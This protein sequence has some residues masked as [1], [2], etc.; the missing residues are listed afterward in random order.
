MSKL[1]TNLV[2][3]FAPVEGDGTRGLQFEVDNAEAPTGKKYVRLYGATKNTVV[4]AT[5]GSQVSKGYQVAEKKVALSFTGGIAANLPFMNVSSVVLNGS[6]TFFNKKGEATAVKL[7]F[8]PD[9]NALVSDRPVY[10]VIMATVKAQYRKL[11]VTFKGGP[12]PVDQSDLGDKGTGD[13]GLDGVFYPMML[14]G[15]DPSY[16]KVAYLSLD[17]PQCNDYNKNFGGFLRSNDRKLA[18]MVLEIEGSGGKVTG[19]N[20]DGLTARTTVRVY[21]AVAPYNINVEATTGVIK[22]AGTSTK[23]LGVKEVVQYNGSSIMS[24]KYPTKA[25]IAVVAQSSFADASGRPLLSARVRLPGQAINMVEWQSDGSYKPLGTR[26]LGEGEIAIVNGFG[27][28][29]RVWG[30]LQ[31]AYST[32][33]LEYTYTPSYSGD[34]RKFN[35]GMIVAQA[36]DR[37]ATLSIS[38]PSLDGEWGNT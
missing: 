13:A 12:C 23:V 33:Y 29:V 26:T 3:S 9:L 8:D 20:S 2:A 6:G 35:Q 11:E 34:T 14:I 22:P 24:T 30:G 27:H 38:G 25:N 18:P 4:R 31:I 10:G 16:S 17:P 36:G 5:T 37:G 7:N 19:G 21:P 1:N 28:P 32:T 15:L